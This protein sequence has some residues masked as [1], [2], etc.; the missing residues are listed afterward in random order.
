MLLK[1]EIKDYRSVAKLA[2]NTYIIDIRLIMGW[3]LSL[4]T[5]YLA[6]VTAILLLTGTIGIFNILTDGR[7]DSKYLEKKCNSGL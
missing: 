2:L 3:L 1:N 4:F 5:T 6:T 7:D